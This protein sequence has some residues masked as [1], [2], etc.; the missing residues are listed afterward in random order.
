[1]T[2][3][4]LPEM[5]LVRAGDLKPFWSRRCPFAATKAG[6]GKG[7]CQCHFEKRLEKQSVSEIISRF[8]LGPLENDHKQYRNKRSKYHKV[9]NI[10]RDKT[11]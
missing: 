5:G 4:S 3:D 11:T 9:Y 8:W 2:D 7:Q 1:M 10:L 6:F